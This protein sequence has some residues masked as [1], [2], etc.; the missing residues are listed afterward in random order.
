MKTTKYTYNPE[1]DELFAD[2]R[3]VGGADYL[4]REMMLALLSDEHDDDSDETLFDLVVGS[5]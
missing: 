2:G 4:T 1:T 3:L 5:A